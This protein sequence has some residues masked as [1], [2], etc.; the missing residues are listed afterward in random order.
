MKALFRF[1]VTCDESKIQKTIAVSKEAFLSEESEQTVSHIEFL[2]QQCKFIKKRWW[3]MQGLLLAFVCFLLKNSETDFTVRRILGLT[4]SLFVILIY[5]E[6]W[7]DLFVVMWVLEKPKLRCFGNR[8]YNILYPSF[9]LCG[10]ADPLCRGRYGAAV[11]LLC[12]R[13]PALQNYAL[14]NAYTVYAPLQCDLLYLLEDPLLQADQ[15]P[16]TFPASVCPLGWSLVSA[17][18]E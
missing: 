18:S 15:F 10:T 8:M 1:D 13:N 6:I 3:L 17:H 5:P 4:G 2:Y 7:I 11:S 9:H 16:G 12:G 14:G